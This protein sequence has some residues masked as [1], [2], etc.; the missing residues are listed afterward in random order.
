M[1][2]AVTRLNTRNVR[3][4]LTALGLLCLAWLITPPMPTPP[5]YDGVGF[6]DE[7]YRYVAPPPGSRPTKPAT[8]VSS[9]AKVSQG[10]AAEVLASSA[11]Q[12][13]QILVEFGEGTLT[14]APDATTVHVGAQPLAPTVQ[15]ADGTVWG[16]VY[17]LTATS[18]AGPVQ[19]HVG[20]GTASGVVMRSPTAPPPEPVIE[21]N[22]GS[23]WRQL[24]TTKSGNDIFTAPLAGLGDYAVVRLRNPP[25]AAGS[26][27]GN[28]YV[29]PIV[30]GVALVVLAGVIVAI[31]IT[32][33]RS[34][35]GDADAPEG[36]DA[37]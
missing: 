26:G 5:L 34:G 16:N 27:G 31:R 1:V 14:A 18:D 32:R 29:L 3:L 8:A 36:Q 28:G 22:D 2:V 33:S 4:L 19:V 13:P 23:G 7:P 11:E 6:P 9:D 30:I 20:A 15:P 35:E 21:Y 10:R 37:S 25:A 17:A 24:Q 12:G